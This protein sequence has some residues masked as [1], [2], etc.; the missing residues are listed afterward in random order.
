MR[1][2]VISD[3]HGNRAAL[4]A[5]ASESHD[6]VICLGDIVGYGPEPQA[7][8]RWVRDNATWVVQGNH[9][10]ANAEHVSPRCQPNFA[11]LAD[12]VVPLTT[13]QLDANDVSY[14]RD[15]PRWGVRDIDGLRVACFHARPSDPLYGYLP[16]DRA[17]WAREIE[18]VEA[19]L[20]LVGHTH[21]PLDFTIG[22]QRVVNPGSVGQPKHGDARSAFAVLV[23]GEPQLKRIAY[24]VDDSIAALEAS[25]VDRRAVGVL[26][27][28]L[29][30]G[31]APRAETGLA[32]SPSR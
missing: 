2:L 13:A 14:L 32:L 22:H 27:E 26:S 12:A 19:D 7:C 8:V 5:V 10:H 16:N 4:A 20:V 28:M 23:D 9:D 29:R 1:V 24:P 11:W 15:L 17:V 21:V 31:E 3:I 18:K 30:T 25:D 6:A